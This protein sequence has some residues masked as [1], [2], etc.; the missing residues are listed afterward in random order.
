MAKK[1]LVTGGAGF[2]GSHVVDLLVACGHTVAVYDNLSTGSISNINKNA[3][4]IFGDI[5]NSADMLEAMEGVDVCIHLAAIASVVKAIDQ[6]ADSST[7]NAVGMANVFESAARKK[8][9][10]VLYAS[11]AA[12]YGIPG[13]VPIK[14][15]DPISPLSP[16]GADKYANEMYGKVADVC[17]G[18]NN[19]GFRFFNVYGPRQNPQSPY[20]GV[21]SIFVDRALS[22][23][24]IVIQGD[25]SQ[26]RDFIF[27]SDV[28]R[29]INYF[30][31]ND[32]PTDVFNVCTQQRIT[33]QELAELVVQQSGM[34]TKIRYIDAR[35]GDISESLGSHAKLNAAIGCEQYVGLNDGIKRL[36]AG[37]KI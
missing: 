13:Q 1:I 34:S 37:I 20:S 32:H 36:L 10:K 16:Y 3:A 11:S 25:G 4:F 5:R 21:I 23:K 12:V 2:I 18:L 33:I 17:Y 6:W 31:D 7:V 24:D 30:V 15:L 19:I 29:I 28:A 35:L 22:G 26:F 9:G 14:E 27:V 8:V